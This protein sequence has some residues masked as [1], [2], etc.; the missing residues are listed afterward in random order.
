MWT[1][2]SKLTALWGGAI[3]LAG[4]LSLDR[5]LPAARKL[6]PAAPVL[7]AVF[8]AICGIQHFVY[9]D[10]VTTLVPPWLPALRF[11]TYFTGTALIA[12]GLGLLVPRTRALAASLSG[13]MIFL[14][15]FLVHIP[16]AA[17]D[18]KNAS[19]MSGVFEALALSGVA[20][21]VAKLDADRSSRAH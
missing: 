6:E 3:L 1:N 18:L 17:A 7:L 14:W 19:E 13:L 4:A 2:P 10:F 8:L 11:W 5:G 15:V 9:A 12:G 20:L 16:R 21:L